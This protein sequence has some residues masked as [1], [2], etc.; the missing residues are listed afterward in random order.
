MLQAA[1]QGV[2]SEPNFTIVLLSTFHVPFGFFQEAWDMAEERGYTRYRW[3][4]YDCM[5]RCQVGLEEATARRPGRPE[6]LPPGVS[7]DRHRP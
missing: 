4:V 1:V 7:S 3:N 6:L 5:A 2:L